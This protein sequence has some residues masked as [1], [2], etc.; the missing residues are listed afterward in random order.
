MFD[1]DDVE[2]QPL[3]DAYGIVM[4]TS[5]TG[6]SVSVPLF[7]S[8][9]N[10]ILEPMMRAQNEWPTFGAQY[11]GNGQWEYDTNNASIIPFFKYGAQRAKPYGANSLFT[12]A[13]RGSGDTAIL[14]TVPEAIQVLNNVVAE[15][16]SILEDVFTGTN[17]SEIPQMWCL[18]KEVQG[19]YETGVTVPDDI[20]LLWADDNW[21]N[22]RRLPLLN[23]TSRSGG[24][25]KLE[26][27]KTEVV[28]GLTR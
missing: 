3:A 4:G 7:Q 28:W 27:V 21:G 26:S 6:K 12:M 9:L 19:Y 16:R 1:V 10:G 25:G 20:T 23:E 5:H 15:Q 14:L 22:T 8:V 17:I 13:M 11:G 2:N 18:Y 24:S